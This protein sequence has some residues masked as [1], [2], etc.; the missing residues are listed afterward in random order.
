MS[1]A[2]R[3]F[4][5]SIIFFLFVAF[6]CGKA[7]NEQKATTDTMVDQTQLLK[8]DIQVTDDLYRSVATV[9]SKNYAQISN[10][11]MGYVAELKVKE[12]DL[13]KEGDVL[14]ILQSKELGSRLEGSM[15]ALGEVES[16]ISEA[17]AADAEAGAQLHLAE[18]T[19]KRFKDLRERESVSQ[20]EFDQ[21]NAAYEV[22]K[23]RKIR[24]EQTL[25]SLYARKKQAGALLDEARTFYE[26]THIKAPFAG[27]VTQK[28]VYE[29]DL[30]ALGTPLLALEDNRHYQ[31][32]AVVD[33]S[34]SVFIK[35]GQDIEV[36][37][38]ALG[39]EKI[40]GTIAEVIPHID[41]N[42]RS[43]QVKIDL[44]ELPLI[45]SGMF[46]KA[47]FKV[48]EKNVLLVPKEA[49]I[50]YGQL[51]SLL[52]VNKEGRVEKRLVKDGKEYDGKVEILS[53]L[54]PG[55]SIV[56]RNVCNVKEGCSV[57]KTL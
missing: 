2:E 37:I 24:A 10:K 48:G 25:A 4:H 6:G 47:F 7:Q 43:F 38:D 57:G 21:A 18:I 49:L 12:G 26:Y 3:I 11:V 22:A 54:D 52:V 20:Q 51:S 31:L 39:E 17:V 45:R 30:A 13:V 5:G 36:R 35:T 55:E 44:P 41:A 28:M 33:E 16:T 40:K 15:N 27:L 50:E 19:F 8:I 34:K 29:G 42:T 53:G 32:E 46:G 23:A 56:A 14:V 1:V 9:K